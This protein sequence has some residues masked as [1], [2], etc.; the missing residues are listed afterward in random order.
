M[1]V[2]LD[3]EENSLATPTLRTLGATRSSNIVLTT[4]WQNVKSY[5]FNPGTGFKCTFY[6]DAKYSTQSTVGNSTTVQTR[7]NCVVNQGS[8]GGN[9]YRFTLSYANTREGSSYWS[10]EDE[11]IMTGESAVQHNTDGTKTITLSASMRVNYTGL[12]ASMSVN[13]DLPRIDRYPMII[14]APDFSDEDNPTITYT[15]I[16]GFSGA[17]VEAGIFDSTGNTNYVPYRQ[18]AVGDGSY[19]FNLTTNERNALRSA[20]PNSNEMNVMYK[21]RTTTTNNVEYFSTSVKQMRII[22]AN[23]TF[24]YTTEEI[25]SNV[26]D[27]LGSSASTV[28]ENAS[29]VRITISPTAYK[30]TT[31]NKTV[32]SHN[33]VQYTNSTSPYVVDL[34]I[35]AD[36][37]NITAVDNRGNAT[38][39][40]I[41]KTLIEYQPVDI[42]SLTMKRVNP[43]SSNIVLNLEATYYQKTFGS[44]ANVPIVK[45]K[46]GDGSYTTIPSSAYTIDTTNNKLTIS[47]YILSNVLVYTSSG[48]FTISIEDLLTSDTDVRNVTKGIPTFDAGEHDLKVNGKIYLADEDGQNP[49]EVG[50]GGDTLPINAIVEYDGNTVPDGWVQVSETA[51]ILWTNPSQT[52]GFTPQEITFSD[53]DYDCYEIIYQLS[54]MDTRKKSTGKVPKG[55][56]TEMIFIYNTGSVSMYI[57]RE[58][59]YVSNTKMQIENSYDSSNG[60]ANNNRCIPIYVIGY[61]TGLFS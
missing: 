10:F 46:L 5:E 39:Q 27:L 42:T 11:T 31:I 1:A 13:V 21:L 37:F 55:S 25:N 2:L 6:L 16:L 19:T 43:T 51:K 45:W 38:T 9:G 60:G 12:D 41:T 56:G 59:T 18:V 33:G 28:V 4:S 53:D 54:L 52:S 30:G 32:V 47:N 3:N 48:Q 50:Q 34:P 7:L 61:N 35:T 36:T 44:T 57:S 15:T 22:N 24:T 58:T 29:Q 49:V 20:T 8:G 40:V 14:T 17:T 23:P 26:V